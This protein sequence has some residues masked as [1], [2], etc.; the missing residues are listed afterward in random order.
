V[1]ALLRAV[2]ESPELLPALVPSGDGVLA[3]VLRP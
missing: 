1:R 3:A 2:E